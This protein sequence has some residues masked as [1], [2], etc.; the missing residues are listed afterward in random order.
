MRMDSEAMN[1]AT[2]A[3]VVAWLVL[4]GL[5]QGTSAAPT[6]AAPLLAQTDQRRSDQVVGY[7]RSSTGAE[8]TLAYTGRPQTLMIQ[9]FPQPGRAQPRLEFTAT[10]LDDRRF[11]YRDASG[12]RL[13]GEVQPGARRISV[14]GA[15]GWSAI[16]ERSR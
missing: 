2:G 6:P 7:W 8:V 12:S 3:A 4:A 14:R 11:A 1:R 10:W 15:N 5:P 13:I 9:V 16:W